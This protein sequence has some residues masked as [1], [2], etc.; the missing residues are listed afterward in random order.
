[1][2]P[3]SINIS[4]STEKLGFVRYTGDLF[5]VPEWQSERHSNIL[6]ELHIILSGTCLL[7]VDNQHYQLE[8]GNA[9]LVRAGKYHAPINTS[10]DIVRCSFLLSAQPGSDLDAQLE[11]LSHFPVVVPEN[12]RNICYQ[13][14]YDNTQLLP[15]CT[16]LLLSKLTILIIEI[17][18]Q[19]NSSKSRAA[20]FGIYTEN[21]KTMLILDRF[22]KPIPEP[23]GTEESLAQELNVSRH[24]LNR[25]IQK[26]YGTNFRQKLF[27]SKMDY[28]SWFLRKTDYTC[29]QIA[30]LCGYSVDTSF[31]KAF[32]TYFGVS[33]A[34]YRKQHRKNQQ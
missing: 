26:N 28:A 32:R 19:V 22:F 9:I 25:I 1:M 24:K 20:N 12:V 17:L 3:A 11:L 34:E 31:H 7:E 18:R 30:T 4:L 8:P 33:P 13:L 27:K 10:K 2:N 16:D 15:Y 29:K 21:Q 6:D 23:F 14:D 5:C